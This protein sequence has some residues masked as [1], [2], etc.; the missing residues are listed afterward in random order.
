MPYLDPLETIGRVVK[1]DYEVIPKLDHYEQ[2]LLFNDAHYEKADYPVSTE[3]TI[4]ESSTL[5]AGEALPQDEKIYEDPGHV[6]E[7]IYEG[8]K[9]RNICNL[10]KS[11]VRYTNYQ[12]H[13]H[14]H[15]HTHSCAHMCMHICMHASYTYVYIYPIIYIAY[16]YLMCA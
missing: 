13:A 4:L 2:P 10:D 5:P 16:S 9:Q 3:S 1:E 8:F 11:T 15:I 14:T 12:T 6:K 7:K